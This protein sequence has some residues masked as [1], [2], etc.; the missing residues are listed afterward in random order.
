MVN[1]LKICLYCLGQLELT[2]KREGGDSSTKGLATCL[3]TTTITNFIERNKD[4]LLSLVG[5][6]KDT[7]LTD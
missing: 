4:V 1:S 5:N 2:T 3:S 7:V 6:L